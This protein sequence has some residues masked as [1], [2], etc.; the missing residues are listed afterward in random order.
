VLAED[1]AVPL[2][3][4]LQGAAGASAI[5]GVFND[6][7]KLETEYMDQELQ[8]KPGDQKGARV[9]ANQRLDT[10]RECATRI[11]KW[12]WILGMVC[13]VVAIIL[14]FTS[15]SGHAAATTTRAVTTGP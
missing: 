12:A 6:T 9:K 2:A 7:G 5:F 10:R 14:V 11:M 1:I 4:L 8:E 15:S 3:A 13:G